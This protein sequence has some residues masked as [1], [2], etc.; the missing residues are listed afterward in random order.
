M[1]VRYEQTEPARFT[2]ETVGGAERITIGAQRSVFVAL[3][4]IVW[5]GGWTFG[6]VAAMASFARHFQP[7]LLFWLCGWALGWAFVVVALGWMLSGSESLRV[8]GS[9]LAISYRLFGLTRTRLFRG[10]DIRGLA[11]CETPFYG[12]TNQVNL[13]FF[14]GSRFG[15]LGFSYGA[16]SVYVGAGLDQAEGRL[17][18]DRLRDRLPPT[19]TLAADGDAL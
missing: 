15:C 18:L 7:F 8:I 13:P 3:F 11:A 6:G 4:L 10:A 2:V 12:R 5:L 16:R 1:S 19:A 17:I 14:G 9:D